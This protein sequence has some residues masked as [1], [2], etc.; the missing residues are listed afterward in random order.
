[1]NDKIKRIFPPKYRYLWKSYS[2]ATYFK[3][4]IEVEYSNLQ[5]IK[6]G[7]PQGSVL[8]LVLYFLYNDLLQDREFMI[9]N[10]T[11]NTVKLATGKDS[12]EA[13]QKI[14][15]KLLIILFLDDEILH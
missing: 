5:K 12:I 10:F 14:F 11:D 13:A 7:E 3:V 9:G 4:W 1:M 6:A 8:E 15:T 2:T